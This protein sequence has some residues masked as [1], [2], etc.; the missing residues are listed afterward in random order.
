M[1]FGHFIEF[2]LLYNWGKE[3]CEKTLNSKVIKKILKKKEQYDVIVMEQFN[4][5]CM[6]AIAHKLNAPFIGV[7]SC[8]LMPWHYDRVS[9]PHIP[10]YIPGLFM[11]YSE[12]MSYSER[13]SN[14]IAVNGLQLLYK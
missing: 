9:N 1:S 11:G 8:A 6:A 5:D 13:L 14:W 4:T 3:S 7:S 2:F 10:S 12:K